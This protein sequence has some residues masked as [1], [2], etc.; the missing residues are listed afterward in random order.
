[1]GHPDPPTDLTSG[2]DTD[3]LRQLIRDGRTRDVIGQVDRIVNTSQD[4]REVARAH[5]M[6]LGALIILGR[7]SECP[8]VI[9][10]ADDA[11]RRHPDPALLG[12]FHALTGFIANVEGSLDRSLRH[13]VCAGRV[14]R[15]VEHN[16]TVSA[17]AWC[18]LAIAYSY[19]GF[20]QQ[21]TAAAAEALRIAVDVGLSVVEHLCLEI[22]VRAAVAYDHRGDTERCRDDLAALL[23]D[24]S[25]V[26]AAEG[27]LAALRPDQLPYVEYAAAR[28]AALGDADA[29]FPVGRIG[30]VR[31]N[32]IPEAIELRELSKVCRAI[33]EHRA[34]E[35]LRR[36]D[37]L[38][39]NPR[40]LGAAETHRLRA[41]ANLANGD[42]AAADAADRAA[43]RVASADL[44]R[45]RA[46]FV[47]GIA[48]RIDHEELRHTVGQHAG[49]A[50]SDPLTGLPNRRC[51]EQRVQAMNADR[52]QSMLGVIDLDGFK[53]VNTLHGHLTGDL[54]LQRVAAVLNRTLRRRDFLARYGGDEFVVIMPSATLAEA[55]A[56]G[57]RLTDALSGEDWESLAPD[58]P[59]TATIG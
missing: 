49:E 21:A 26:L 55:A 35:A 47:D 45:V 57:R 24:T 39:V 2:P 37:R 48:V 12:E 53:S 8:A 28:L 46:L 5:L 13:L 38:T 9:D 56:V 34:P 6:K 32:G 15:T 11:L 30:T 16:D 22:G 31:H 54:V 3:Q 25:R 52:E 33:A 42:H 20:H 36:L 18:D 41:L 43:F 1:M 14:L 50:F 19:V 40:T 27:G 7:T 29:A 23:S 58:T 4:P 44:E 10:Q 51:L 59:V 17:D